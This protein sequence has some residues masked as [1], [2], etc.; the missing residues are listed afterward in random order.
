MEEWPNRD[1]KEAA[2]WAINCSVLHERAEKK[3]HISDMRLDSPEWVKTVNI[4]VAKNFEQ[5]QGEPFILAVEPH[6][7][8]VRLIAERGT[9]MFPCDISA[10]FHTNLETTLGLR[11][12]Y[13][14][15]LPAEEWSDTMIKDCHDG[16][17]AILKI[18]LP[19][20]EPRK[21]F[22]EAYEIMSDLRM[23]NITAATLFPGLD[24]F[25][26]SMAY[27][28]RHVNERPPD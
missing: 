2:V 12:G 10:T 8:D 20:I 24:G 23:M 7:L 21:N 13:I 6:R 5:A 4:L 3:F 17:I 15:D 22:A 28:L 26:R 14:F 1:V 11:L 25:A 9:F 19:C 16:N 18:L 27:H